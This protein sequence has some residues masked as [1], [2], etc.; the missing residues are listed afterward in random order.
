[1]NTYAEKKRSVPQTRQ[2]TPGQE[3]IQSQLDAMQNVDVHS[4]H[5]LQL[6]DSLKSRIEQHLGYDLSGVELRESQ[7][8]ANMGAEAFAKGNVVHFAPG[9]FDQHST[10]GQHLIAHE[11]SHVVQQA[12]GG[13][14][15]DVDGFNV[16][17]SS[18]FESA[19]DHAGDSFVSGGHGS[20]S[21]PLASLPSMNADAAPIQGSFMDSI[22]NFFGIKKREPV[23]S[24]PTEVNNFGYD[25]ELTD[26]ERGRMT[27]A[28]TADIANF[29]MLKNLTP[30]YM[31]TLN[32]RDF[33]LLNEMIGGRV[34]QHTKERY[35]AGS[36]VVEK[37]VPMRGNFAAMTNQ[38]ALQNK[39]A[40]M[41]GSQ[42]KYKDYILNTS[43]ISNPDMTRVAALQI[44]KE[45]A[46]DPKVKDLLEQTFANY[47]TDDGFSKNDIGSLAMNHFALRSLAPKVSMEAQ[48]GSPQAKLN[49]TV[50][51]LVSNATASLDE[52]GKALGEE[53]Y[54]NTGLS[55]MNTGAGTSLKAP[56]TAVNT[57]NLPKQP[58]APAKKWWQ[59]W[60]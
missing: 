36:T 26:E 33:H 60:K 29:K 18:A 59:F 17:A 22:K 28:T 27:E 19:A 4:G 2:T 44:A 34:A 23:I 52:N 45:G 12:R 10:Q 49:K 21:A 30:E 20:L 55:D 39:Y 42:Q 31:A 15:A 40:A 47:S 14:H 41:N 57:K 1:M 8:A 16:N 32:D 38:V 9:Q 58:A 46:N 54:A 13:V 25:Q 24:G 51:Q 53:F 48:V 50:L 37:R 43:S 7:D 35:D 3:H 56:G 6:E 11:L 5:S